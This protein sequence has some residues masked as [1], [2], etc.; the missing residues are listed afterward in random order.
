MDLAGDVMGGGGTLITEGWN[1]AGDA[2]DTG[3]DV[4]TGAAGGI[5]GDLASDATDTVGDLASDAADTIIDIATTDVGVTV[6]DATDAV[7]DVAEDAWNAL[8]DW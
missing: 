1:L 6:D 4:G 7:E 2:F 3:I 5:V 8:T